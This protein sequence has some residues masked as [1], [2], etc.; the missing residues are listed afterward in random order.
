MRC[1]NK[2]GFTACR[3]PG[4][5]EV[6]DGQL[7][8]DGICCVNPRKCCKGKEEGKYVCCNDAEEIRLDRAPRV[9]V[10]LGASPVPVA[11]PEPTGPEEIE[12]PSP[13]ATPG[14]EPP[15]PAQN[16]AGTTPGD[17]VSPGDDG[18]IMD[19]SPTVEVLPEEE[20]EGAG[21]DQTGE[22]DDGSVCLPGDAIVEVRGKGMTEVA[23][24]RSGDSVR[25]SRG[26]WSEVFMWTHKDPSYT[27]RRYVELWADGML[28]VTEGHVVYV[29]RDMKK[30]CKREM[31]SV[32][33]VKVGDGVWRLE[34]EERV[35]RVEKV[36]RG[37]S[38]WGLFNPQTS[39][40]DIVVDGVVVTCYSRWIKESVAHGL[41][42]PIRALYKWGGLAFEVS[43]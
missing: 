30:N 1:V 20:A 16:G 32:E 26:E 19:P 12:E 5:G 38:G 14:V 7:C 13:D 15:E 2:A 8:P 18:D 6:S 41:L 25:V 17:G 37:V 4:T 27:G 42:A 40:G 28:K 34:S 23:N 10:V 24:V 31:A 9:E 3:D 21:G 11:T 39:S 29:C 36:V 22:D 35:V 33:T 43:M